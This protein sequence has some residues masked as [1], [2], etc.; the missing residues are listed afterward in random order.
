MNKFL[1]TVYCH[2][3]AAVDIVD[4]RNVCQCGRAFLVTR[5]RARMSASKTFQD[6]AI[7]AHADGT[8]LAWEEG[9]IVKKFRGRYGDGF[10]FVGMVTGVKMMFRYSV[11]EE[12]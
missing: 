7:K 5:R 11:T 1:M 10:D 2:C 6:K 4:T 12:K 3:G 8:I 9:V